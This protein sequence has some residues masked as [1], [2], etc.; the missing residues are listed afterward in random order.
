MKWL[1]METGKNLSS[2]LVAPCG[3]NCTLCASYL[4]LVND[5]KSKGIRMPYCA[6]CRP[7]NKNCAF[8]KKQCTRLMNGEVAFCFECSDF[9]CDR[10]RT[11]DSRY[12]SRY[13]M[14]MIENLNF[15]KEHGMQNFLEKQKKLWKCLN[16]GELICCHNGICFKCELEKMRSKKEK[17]RWHE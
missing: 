14:S 10:L 15:I 6:G 11:I 1:R 9:P 4:A 3:M 5:V 16:C 2:D 17:F 13:R 8:L 12:K 7:R